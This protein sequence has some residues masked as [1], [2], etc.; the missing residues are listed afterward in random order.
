MSMI[1][2]SQCFYSDLVLY[3]C[4]LVKLFVEPVVGAL[5]YSIRPALCSLLDAF[6]SS[7]GSSSTA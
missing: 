7:S 1:A 4:F 5:V 3:P 2:V 6:A